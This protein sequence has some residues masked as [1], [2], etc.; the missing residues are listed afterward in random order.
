MKN[1]VHILMT[2]E[3][4]SIKLNNTSFDIMGWGGEREW[5][6]TNDYLDLLRM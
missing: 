3:I 4:N 6:C 1:F 5:E 2:N